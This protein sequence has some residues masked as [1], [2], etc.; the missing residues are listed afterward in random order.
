MNVEVNNTP[1]LHSLFDV[2]NSKFSISPFW[3]NGTKKEHPLQ[4][5]RRC[6]LGHYKG[7][8]EEQEARNAELLTKT[9]T[10]F[11]ILAPC[12]ATIFFKAWGG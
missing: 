6:R 10:L 8:R 5:S 11:N 12:S 3:Q 7:K 4:G 9:N 1:L 2:R